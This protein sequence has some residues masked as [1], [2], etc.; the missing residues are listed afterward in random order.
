MVSWGVDTTAVDLTRSVVDS[1]GFFHADAAEVT[2][3]PNAHVIIDDGRRFLL[4]I[5]KDFDVIVLDPP[6]PPSAAGSSL[7]YSVEF[8]EVA[9]RHLR[10]H[11]ILQQW[12]PLQADAATMEAML[13]SLQAVFPHVAVYQQI[14]KPSWALRRGLHF[15]ASMD[16]IPDLTPEEFVA[17]LPPAAQQDL[18]EWGPERTPLEMAALILGSRIPASDVAASPHSALS[19]TDDRPFNEYYL[20]RKRAP[21]LRFR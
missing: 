7:L 3:R 8:Y 15:I 12:A 21:W 5:D 20:L 2:A 13:G 10:P 18:V 6:P 14:D 19:I 9:R 11:G 16:P 4:R 1:F 17:R